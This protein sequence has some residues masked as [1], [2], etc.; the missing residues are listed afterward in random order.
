MR[1]YVLVF[2]LAAMLMLLSSPYII[3]ASE[4]GFFTDISFDVL[5]SCFINYL[6]GGQPGIVRISVVPVVEDGRA[7]SYESI[8][9]FIHN[10]TYRLGSYAPASEIIY[11]GGST[12]I[13]L[14]IARVPVTWG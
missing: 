10:F 5:W 8:I 3:L 1:N 4:Y 14:K 9:V 7:L 6:R 11:C 12:R 13:S 2:V